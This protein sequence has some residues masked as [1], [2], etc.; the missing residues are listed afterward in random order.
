MRK[1][2][3]TGGTGKIGERLVC[4]MVNDNHKVIFTSRSID[5]AKKLIKKN[6]LPIDKCLPIELNFDDKDS[7]K[8]LENQ[9]Q[10]FPD[11]I[12]NNARSLD[13]LKLDENK[14][15]STI[16]F[17]KEFYYGIIYPYK[18]I[19]FFKLKNVL[20]KDII[21]ISSIYG[22]VAPNPSLYDDFH[23]ESSINY[24]VVKAA[25]IHL[26]KELAVRLGSGSRVN[27]ISY[28]GVKGRVSK[29]FKN[30]YSNLTPLGK[31][32][33]NKDL[34]PPIK[35][36]LDNKDLKITGENIKVDGGWTIW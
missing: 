32:L 27:A 10:F 5:K 11:T 14:E 23:T 30:R 35:L 8:K 7:F 2:L 6:R 33:D 19:N 26:V 22:S 16:N 9:L 3:I 1:I 20:I 18:I 31:M 28:G 13:N 21:F 4:D 17:Q 29:S 12:I 15:I 36:L 25:Q 24:G 34:Y